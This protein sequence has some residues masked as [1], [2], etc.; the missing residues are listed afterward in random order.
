MRLI[1]APGIGKGL[2]EHYLG[3]K[4]TTVIAAVRDVTGAGA[5]SLQALPR[6]EG[7][8][9]IIVKIDS[10]SSTDAKEAAARLQSEH[11]ISHVDIAIANAGIFGHPAPVSEWD[12]SQVQSMM[13]VNVYGLV[14]LFQ[15]LQPLLHNSPAPKL[16]Y[17][18]SRLGSIQ[19]SAQ[20]ALWPGAYGM[21]KAAGNFVVAKI[22][23]ENKWLNVLSVD[24]G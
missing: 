18:S 20:E 22:G 4:G 16:V 5:E 11:Q 10:N 9:L 6:S 17:V 8:E 15:A 24:P 23:A 14:H 12:V 2:T 21:S 13:D 1:Y 19:L 3:R 7:S